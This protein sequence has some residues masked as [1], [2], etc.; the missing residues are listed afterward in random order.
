MWKSSDGLKSHDWQ[1]RSVQIEIVSYVLL[2][3]I[4]RG[5][6]IDGITLLKWLSQQRNHLGSFRTTQVG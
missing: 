4:R 6:L 5:T 2:T 3:H 1:P